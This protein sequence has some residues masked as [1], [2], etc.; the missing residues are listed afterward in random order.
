MTHV[1]LYMATSIDWYIA[2]ENWNSEWISESDIEVFD[3]IT[4]SSDCVIIWHNTYEQYKW[5][6]YPIKDIINIVV[7]SQGK[8][9][10]SH[11]YF[12]NSPRDAI[13]F[14]RERWCLNII[15]VWWWHINGSFLSQGL[16]DEIIID[17]QPIILG[18]WIK[19]FEEVNKQIHLEFS[20]HQKVKWWLNILKYKVQK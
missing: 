5:E 10:T 11:I 2:T 14:A 19:L 13:E 18:K 7:S 3:N 15:L 4:Q 1:T 12:K 17:I 6:I 8:Q 16:I 9:N 20:E